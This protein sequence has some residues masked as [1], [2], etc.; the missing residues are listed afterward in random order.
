MK[1]AHK[2]SKPRRTGSKKKGGAK[3]GKA[4]AKAKTRKAP[5][6]SKARP[7]PAR[8]KPKAKPRP[9]AAGARKGAA[10]K[11]KAK[12]GSKTPPAVKPKAPAK[13][14]AHAP[15]RPKPIPAGPPVLPAAPPR[16]SKTA[17]RRPAA[18]RSAAASAKSSTATASS[19]ARGESGLGPADLRAMREKLEKKREDILAMYRRDLKS[20]QE[21]TDENTDDLVDRANNAYNRELNFALSGNERVLLFQVEE[22]LKRLDAETFGRCVNCG[23]ALT[24]ARLEALPWARYCIDCQ[25]LQEKGLLEEA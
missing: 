4:K 3:A 1:T 7:R 8:P 18:M 13:P 23:R 5:V 22:S 2:S 21:A 25:E 11:P 10:Q 24:R 20:G 14:T 15:L 16:L 19:S 9:K 12:A 17:A 6:K